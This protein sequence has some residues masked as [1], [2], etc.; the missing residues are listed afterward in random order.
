MEVNKGIAAVLVGGIAFFLTGMIG[1]IL[2]HETLPE[3]PVLNI[4][5]PEAPAAGGAAKPAGPAQTPRSASRSPRRS[6]SRAIP[7]TRAASRAS[8]RTSMGSS[9]ARTTT[10]R[11]STIHRPCR[12]SKGSL[13][14]SMP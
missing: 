1:D 12:S 8:A 11:A 10:S 14:P 9:A 5:A 7:S 6:A 13:G 2:V 3:K 4:A